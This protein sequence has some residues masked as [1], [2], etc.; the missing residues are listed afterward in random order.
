MRRAL[1][2][3]AVLAVGAARASAAPPPPTSPSPSPYV[4]V[5]DDSVTDVGA[6]IDALQ[7]GLGFTAKLRY[8]SALGGFAANFTPDQAARIADAPGVAFV[9]PDITFSA[10]GLAPLAAGETVPAGIRRVGGVLGTQA[11]AAS[12]VGVAVLDTGVDL[13]NGDLA[14]VSGTNCVKPGT[15]A[16]DDNGHGTHVAGIVAARNSGNGVVGVAPGTTVYAV[17]VLGPKATGTLSQILCGINWVTANAAALNIKVANMSITGLGAND[18]ACGNVNRDAEHKAICGS[19]AAGVTYVAAAGNS[20]TNFVNSVPAAYPEVLTATAMSDSDG[21]AGAAGPAPACRKGEKDDAYGSY[22]NYAV[23]AS[24]QS[25]TI[26]APGTCVV[27]DA[28]GG[29][30]AVYY[31]TSQAA[32]HV[33]GAAAL[34][35]DDG[36]VP[37]PCAGLSP[38][39][40]VQRLRT[41]AAAAATL[42]NGFAGDPLRPVTGRF[43]GYL[44]A[45]DSY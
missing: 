28:P 3:I 8:S 45:A 17:K 24:E 30:T 27:S 34:C 15:P 33:A 39:Q 25:H 41:D 22:S 36:G 31:G 11:H 9:D 40:I 23:A 29:K 12:S 20:A 7:R 18:N 16:A 10:E 42:T 13:T 32:P 26:A 14:A 35:L 44:V 2:I 37:G 38:T 19:V 4:V 43:Y 21:L 5:F 1:W 6:R